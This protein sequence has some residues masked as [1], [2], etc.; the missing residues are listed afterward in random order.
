VTR[1]SIFQADPHQHHPRAR[2]NRRRLIASPESAFYSVE[3][4]TVRRAKLRL[5]DTSNSYQ[6]RNDPSTSV[7]TAAI[8]DGR[9]TVKWQVPTEA[10][11]L[12]APP[13]ES[14]KL[15]PFLSNPHTGNLG[16][17]LGEFH[18]ITDH[19]HA[20]LECKFC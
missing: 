4:F 15:L 3:V 9:F 20:L 18:L 5:S 19:L 8:R 7:L 2:C 12:F 1:R 16:H 17:L 6:I 13:S 11:A 14:F 10:A